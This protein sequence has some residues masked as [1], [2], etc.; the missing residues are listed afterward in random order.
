MHEVNYER[1][2][3]INGRELK[4][5]GIFKADEIF[6]KMNRLIEEREYEKREKKSEEVVLESGRKIYVELRPF[7]EKSSYSVL[8]IKIRVML[9]NVTSTVEEFKGEKRRFDNGD[10]TIIFDAWSLTDYD[11]RWEMKPFVFFMKGFINKFIYTF[12][13]EAGNK[14]EVVADTAYIYGQM[15]RFLNSYK[16]E[17]GKGP[18]EAD[19]AKKMEE[20]VRK[21]MESFKEEMEQV[22]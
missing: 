16:Y 13:I 3:I 2:L 12:P 22:S 5:K 14:K 4:Y 11:E 10:V 18:L 9:D 19:V 1:E 21:E 20:E 6:S 15:K 8:M 7:K 17:V